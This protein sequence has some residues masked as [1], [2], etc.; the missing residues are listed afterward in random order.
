MNFA[1]VASCGALV[2]LKA[3]RGNGTSLISLYIPP[4]SG[5]Q[6]RAHD[7]LK[8]ELSVYQSIKD[9]AVRHAV[10]VE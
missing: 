9:R 2:P 8:K 1:I 3:A 6:K 7:V 4:T 5:Q 10:K